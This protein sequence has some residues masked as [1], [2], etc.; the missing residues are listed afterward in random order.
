[1]HK[2][3][4][5][6]ILGSR[7]RRF[8]NYFPEWRSHVWKSL[9]NRFTRDPKYGIDGNECIVLSLTRYFMRWT[10][11]SAKTITKSKYI[12]FSRY[13]IYAHNLGHRGQNKINV[14]VYHISYDVHHV[15]LAEIH[16][17]FQLNLRY[18]THG[19]RDQMAAIWQTTFLNDFSLMNKSLSLVWISL[20]Y[21]LKEHLTFCQH[22][23]KKRLGDYSAPSHYPKP[24]M[25]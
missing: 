25:A 15:T 11:T 20:N 8:A 4:W 22:W 9:A 12:Y 2:L 6:T 16:L 18:M 23:F 5:I 19:S 21:V 7:V 14:L 3:P 13:I 10:H 1:M 17:K 24:M